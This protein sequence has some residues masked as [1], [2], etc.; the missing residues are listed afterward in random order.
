MP[1]ATGIIFALLSLM[2]AGLLWRTRPGTQ[3]APGRASLWLRTAIPPLLLLLCVPSGCSGRIAD[4]FDALRLN[5][6]GL[7]VAD[8]ERP[9]VS[10]VT[11]PCAPYFLRGEAPAIVVGSR[12]ECV[13]LVVAD[14][15]SQS[16]VEGALVRVDAPPGGEPRLRL[17]TLLNDASATIVSYREGTERHYVG[18]V[19]ISDGYRFCLE[20][21]VG[22][23]ASWWV[24]RSGA[25]ISESRP[26]DVRRLEVRESLLGLRSPYTPEERISRLSDTL[27]E[28]DGEGRCVRE[29]SVD[30]TRRSVGVRPAL[31]F[32]F[33]QSGGWRAMLLDPGVRLLD[34]RGQQVRPEWILETPLTHEGDWRV[35]ILAMRANRLA[36]LR[37]F[38]I[39]RPAV[40]HAG[41][42]TF[43]IQLT[44]DTPE[45]VAIGRCSRP[46]LRLSTAS[47]SERAEVVGFHS[48]GN[49]P[50]SFLA[51][52][53]A[54]FPLAAWDLCWTT[55]HSFTAP[56]SESADLKML[57]RVDRLGFPWLLVA[58]AAA[59]AL[60]FHLASEKTWQRDR[61]DGIL[62][63]LTLYLLTLRT[64]IAIEG[65][66]VDPAIDWRLAYSESGM[67]LVALPALLV[68][69]RS[70]CNT[71]PS[72]PLSII[73]FSGAAYASLWL[74]LG[75]LDGTGSMLAL[76]SLG[77]LALHALFAIRA[78]RQPGGAET[79]ARRVF[80]DR[81]FEIPAAFWGGLLAVIVIVRGLFWLGGYGERVFGVPLSPIYLPLLLI[82]VAALLAEA[83]AADELRRRQLGA[84]FLVV[85]GIAVVALP[86]WIDDVGFAFV[87]SPILAGLA[88]WRLRLWVRAGNQEGGTPQ[89]FLTRPLW[90]FPAILLAGAVPLGL[91]AFHLTPPPAPDANLEARVAASIEPRYLDTDQLRLR[92]VFAPAQIRDIGNRAAA[93]QLEQSLQLDGLTDTLFG[94]GYL[95]AVDL[96]GLTYKA[97]HLSDYVS[98]T[99]IMAPFGRFGAVALLFIL[100]AAAGAACAGGRLSYPARWRKLA[101]ALAVWTLFGTAAYMILSNLSL[102]PFT[103]R[104]IYL[105]AATSGG[106][107]VEGFALILIARLGLAGGV[108]AE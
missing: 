5:F 101:G 100:A 80:A 56:L 108:G 14:P 106:D 73:L 28:R 63:A 3:P 61:L 98:A 4:R 33:Q 96:G 39:S 50:G 47:T 21:C 13:D 93:A 52:A 83:E 12:H 24:F 70:P 69:I 23:G 1:S 85:L 42:T 53:A 25:L 34:A 86:R 19:D 103:G 90:V 29:A 99:H 32:L 59:V 54:G 72:V 38:R 37:S 48:A 78:K 64:M 55:S 46:P 45:Q 11:A 7:E 88:L 15:R 26:T 82:C 22:P 43:P 36:E 102:A 58:L 77:A 76:I 20:D 95:A 10:G 94:R 79:V 104:N 2:F 17:A 6:T 89:L 75:E 91:L 84:A 68:A 107:L 66:F 67:A 105:L 31:T 81:L 51:S 60:L 65:V 97:V 40:L 87:L 8:S 71:N 62:F 30:P 57:F 49:R 27:C 74:W 18:A 44:L 35:A 41:A 16:P 9:L 92:A